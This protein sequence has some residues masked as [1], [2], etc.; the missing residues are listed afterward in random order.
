M[1]NK[2]SVTI[3]TKNEEKNIQRCLNSVKWADEIVVVDSGSTDKTVSI[4]EN[5]GCK[6]IKTE[7]KGFGKTKKFAVDNA[8]Y[9]W[10]FSIDADEE[11]TK[12]LKD[13]IQKILSYPKARCYKL[14][15]RSYYL[16]KKIQYCGWNN[17]YPLRLFNRKYG[18]FNEK[19]VHESVQLTGR[20]DRIESELVHYTYPTLESHVNRMIKYAELSA[21]QK[22]KNGKS[23]TICGAIIRSLIKFI[24]MYFFQLG[25]LDG[26]HGLLLSL[27][28]SYGV[29]LKY[30]KLWEMNRSK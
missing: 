11:V 3:I 10:I 17:D 20:V 30:L 24:K 14:K 4:C 13:H 28:S 27:N 5:F 18:N 9:N 1:N 25:L 2:L 12:E 26:K 22:F 29:F 6:V 23:V 16:G 15:R 8:S 7:W 19:I 21:K